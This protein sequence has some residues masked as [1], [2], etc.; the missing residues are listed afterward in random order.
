MGY[1][2][3]KDFPILCEIVTGLPEFN[4]R[5]QGVRKGCTLGKHVKDDLPR[6]EKRYKKILDLIHSNVCG[7]IS[8][9]SI[10]GM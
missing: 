6:S 2:H 7:L 4:I 8:L 5:K 1:F 3:Y 9:V 10:L